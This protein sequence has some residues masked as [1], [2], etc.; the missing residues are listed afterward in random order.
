M[1]N[2]VQAMIRLQYSI[3]IAETMTM[4]VPSPRKSGQKRR[5][6]ATGPRA[7]YWPNDSSMNIS[8]S[9]AIISIMVKG[10]RK[11]PASMQKRHLDQ[12]PNLCVVKLLDLPPPLL[13]HRQ[14]KRH[15]LPRPTEQPSNESRK[16]KRPVQLPRSGSFVSMV[17]ASASSVTSAVPD[18]QPAMLRA[19]GVVLSCGITVASL[20]EPDADNVNAVAF[21]G[22][23][24]PPPTAPPPAAPSD[25]ALLFC[26]SLR[27][28]RSAPN[29]QMVKR[30]S[31]C[32]NWFNWVSYSSTS[33]NHKLFSY[34]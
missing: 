29:S 12:V 19:V 32:C 34:Q 18:A 14:G 23:T 20:P 22:Q 8:G 6:M 3:T 28:F 25:P 9:P 21:P 17:T 10:I 4:P 2:M 24:I 30:S 7:A 31:F 15:T 1:Q 16:S 33:T 13:Q 5:Q 26:A 11:A 27:S